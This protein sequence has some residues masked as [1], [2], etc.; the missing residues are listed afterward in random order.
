[1]RTKEHL[2]ELAWICR[3]KE[4][5]DLTLGYCIV[6]SQT[7]LYQ[8]PAPGIRDVE[9]IIDFKKVKSVVK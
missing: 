7:M 4:C 6:C 9:L 1:L 2:N 8:T 5:P 3:I